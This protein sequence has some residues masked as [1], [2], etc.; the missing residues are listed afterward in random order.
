MILEF[1]IGM[2][3]KF[4]NFVD[5]FTKK[6]ISVQKK[7]KKKKKRETFNSFFFIPL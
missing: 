1:K 7:K 6:K 3:L 2:H 4:M 5:W